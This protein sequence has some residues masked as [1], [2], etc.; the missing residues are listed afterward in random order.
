[1]W[2]AD[3]E[4]TTGEMQ[5]SASEHGDAYVNSVQDRGSIPLAS[6]GKSG[7][8]KLPL[9][10]FRSSPIFMYFK[11]TT[12]GM[13]GVFSSMLNVFLLFLNIFLLWRFLRPLLIPQFLQ[14]SLFF[15]CVV[16]SIW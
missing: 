10:V 6:I 9:L 13:V 16:N 11:N 3:A 7:S 4:R 5:Q 14:K 2:K 1:M 15:L 12:P 8:Y